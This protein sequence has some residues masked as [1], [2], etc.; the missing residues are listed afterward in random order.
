MA[1]ENGKTRIEPLADRLVVRPVEQPKMSK[2]GLHIP[3]VAQEKQQE[4]E[5]VSVGEGRMT[6][7]GRLV[8]LRVKAG[9]RVLFGRFSGTELELDGGKVLILREAD[10]LAVVHRG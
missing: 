9:D 6:D 4:G 8:A 5:V 2:G 3:D 10:V 1:S 7:E